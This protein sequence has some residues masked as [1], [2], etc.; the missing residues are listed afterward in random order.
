MLAMPQPCFCMKPT[1]SET[2]SESKG[3]SLPFDACLFFQQG[4]QTKPEDREDKA[5]RE[6]KF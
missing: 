5:E 2:I 4:W 6:R 1:D 3:T